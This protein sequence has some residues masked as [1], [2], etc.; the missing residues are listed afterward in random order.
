MTLR[1]I[2]PSSRSN[3]L[4]FAL[5]YFFVFLYFAPIENGEFIRRDKHVSRI[6]VLFH[7]L[8][9]FLPYISCFIYTG[10]YGVY[11]PVAFYIGLLTQSIILATYCCG[12][13]G[14]LRN[15]CIILIHL[16]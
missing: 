10:R 3:V 14:S 6:A 8:T 12:C 4:V 16:V 15:K 2:S 9:Y 11:S 7:L 1:V 5:I 13:L